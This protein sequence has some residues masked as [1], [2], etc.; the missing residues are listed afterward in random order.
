MIEL[1]DLRTFIVLCEE[2]HFGRTAERLHLTQS[3]VSKIVSAMERDLGGLLFDRSS[4]R[5]ELTELGQRFRAEVTPEYHHLLA[6]LDRTRSAAQRTR[7]RVRIGVMPTAGSGLAGLVS[8]A[9]LSHPEFE[10][11]LA[12]VPV[13]DG[14]V[15]DLLRG[16]AIDVLIAWRTGRLDDLDEGP[17]LAES[18]RCAA[19]SRHHP[20]ATRESI[21]AQEVDTWGRNTADVCPLF[22]DLMLPPG[23]R[24]GTARIKEVNMNGLSVLATQLTLGQFV[25]LTAAALM[26]IIDNT[27]IVFVPIRDLPPL[28]ATL[29]TRRG[30][31]NPGVT[32]FLNEARKRTVR[33]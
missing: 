10:F 8:D 2:L 31:R 25:W 11:V 13:A 15:H 3:R 12:E 27:D 29:V 5:V 19:M 24:A 32:A 30:N 21:L 1:A 28:E 23:I 9:Q 6:A 14:D 18:P 20:L 22:V 7:T 17:A 33:P 16:S 26:P 4:R